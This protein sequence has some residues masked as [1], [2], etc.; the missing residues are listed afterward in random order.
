MILQ[1]LKEYYDRKS[2]FQESEGESTSLDRGDRIA[3][4]GFEWKEIPWVIILDR[5]GLPLAIE[6]TRERR[7]KKLKGRKFLVPHSVLRGNDLKANLL[8]DGLDYALGIDTKGKG[9]PNRTQQQHQLFIAGIKNLLLD[10]DEAVNAVSLFLE[11]EDM[12]SLL[13]GL[14]GWQDL[15]DD[16]APNVTFRLAGDTSTV[17]ERRSVFGVITNSVDETLPTVTCMVS[18]ETDRL[19][20][21]HSKI[22][23]VWGAQSS[24]GSIVSF[25]ADAFESYG[26]I[27][28]MNAPVGV[29]AATAYTTALNHLLREDSDQ[30]MQVGDTSTVFWSKRPS[31]FE[32]SFGS[33]FHE[34]PKDDPDRMS[35]AVRDLFRSVETGVL[36]EQG[37]NEFYVLGLA[38][39]AGR[40]AI[41][42]W[43]HGRIDEMAEAIRQH[44]LDIQMI[45]GPKDPRFLSLFRLLVSIAAQGKADNIPSHLSESIMRA[46]LERR[47]YPRALLQAA[48]VRI[49]AEH[50]VNYPRASIVKACLNRITRTDV[51]YSEKEMQMSLDQSN[52]NAGYLLG[53]LF[54]ALERVQEEASPGINATIRD[55]FYGAASSTPVT[56]FGNLMRQK[57]H[58]IAKIENPGRQVFYEK[59]I[60]QI[61][62][63]IDDFPAHLTL[64]DQGRFAIGYYHQRQDFYTKKADKVEEMGVQK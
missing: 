8:W 30:R 47:Q 10:D 48:L 13:S 50:E 28:G 12:L 14:A 3:P 7:G 43:L 27:Q 55:R 21:L 54:A 33:F 6:D 5:D 39:N 62:E 4:A 45:H 40:I 9:D 46:I 18:G 36:S 26:K 1:A 38:P 32:H 17:G 59:L 31:S 57:N 37:N 2:S 20:K 42:F 56:V 24:G 25:N 60:G 58:H 44:F 23:N 61:V 52:R 35:G 22:K 29:A 51:A 53:R 41:R 49:R 34:P 63:G 16:K 11:R 64:D 15:M 19:A